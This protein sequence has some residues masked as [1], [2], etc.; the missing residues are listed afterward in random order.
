MNAPH[1]TG[2]ELDL[3][4]RTVFVRRWPTAAADATGA[5]AVMV[6]GLGGQ[7][8]NWTDFMAL[9]AD[10]L[11]AWA[12]D[13]PGFGWSPPPQDADY[14]MAADAAVVAALIEQRA[15]ASGQP[16]HLFGNSMGGAVSVLAAAARPERVA[17]LT[18]ISPAMPDLRPRRGTVG[19]PLVA[20]PGVGTRL[21]S[22]LARVPADRQVDG[23]VALNYGDA[24]TFTAQRRD[25]ALVEVQRRLALPYA[26]EVLSGAARGLLKAFLDP[27]PNGLWAA[28][29]KV[30]CPTLVIYGGR[31]RLVDP[32]RARRVARHMPHA[33]FVTL[34]TVG[35]VAQME[36]PAL[37]ARF[38]RPMLDSSFGARPG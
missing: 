28:A 12:P 9:M 3:A 10:R 15:E 24:S 32:R 34:P 27:G 4:G 16:V 13:L 25:E 38:V 7:S 1:P 22:R 8:T 21:Y 5:P 14:S 35:H 30:D 19:V 18:L 11:D 33:S 2:V 31:D 29:A 20:L 17:S 6:H 26:G 23:M 37:L 36:D